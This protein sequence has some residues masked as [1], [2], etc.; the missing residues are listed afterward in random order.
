VANHGPDLAEGIA[1]TIVPDPRMQ[2]VQAVGRGALSCSGDKTLIICRASSLSVEGAASVDLTEV[3]PFDLIPLTT[4]F[5]VTSTTTD[6]EPSNDR[7]VKTIEVS[8]EPDLSLVLS[9][10]L[11]GSPFDPG[12]TLSAA[13]L[14]FNHS[15]TVAHDVVVVIDTTRVTFQEGDNGDFTC[16]PTMTGARC[17]ISS[18]DNITRFLRFS[19]RADPADEGGPFSINLSAS[20]REGEFYPDDNRWTLSGQVTRLLPVTSTADTGSG[21]LRQAILDSDA[22]CRNTRPCKIVFRLAEPL[23][24]GGWYTIRPQSE[25]PKLAVYGL[26]LDGA[27]QTAFGGDT[28]PGGPEVELSGERMSKGHGL[29]AGGS[30]N[31]AIRGL[32]ITNFPGNGIEAEGNN[33]CYASLTIDGNTIGLSPDGR[34][35]APNE[36]GIVVTS[37]LGLFVH[38]NVISGNR[39]SGIFIATGGY[40]T[41]ENNRIGLLAD[42]SPMPNG[43]SGIYVGADSSWTHMNANTI[44]YH[45]DFGIAMAAEARTTFH[46]NNVF[47]NHTF[48]IDRGM[49]YESADSDDDLHRVPNRPQLTAATYDAASGKT[50]V[51]GTLHIHC[52]PC[53]KSI[54]L[55]ASDSLAPNG[56]AQAQRFVGEMLVTPVDSSH[57]L[58]QLDLPGDLRGKFLTATVTRLPHFDGFSLSSPAVAPAE[59]YDP[60]L[61]SGTSE[62]SPAIQAR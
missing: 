52:N 23:P 62:L 31:T 17:T 12:Q 24:P 7:L 39:R 6:W 48:A 13:F 30:C 38:D 57:F 53:D 45:Q 16:T 33:D 59:S 27:T 32:A 8:A 20:A 15:L 19:V 49:D 42:G 26:I 51:G 28:N 36:R 2:Q 18:L 35:A 5:A 43:A 60:D 46:Q 14:L 41:I 50:H 40:S 10:G 4:T 58:L 44:A 11:S 25:L 47:G 37:R 54:E 61:V 22:L 21:S 9:T 1:L 29:V 55:F 56:T 34:H 3:V